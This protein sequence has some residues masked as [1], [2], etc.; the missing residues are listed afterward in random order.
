MR[1]Y[2][3][4]NPE[5]YRIGNDLTPKWE[6]KDPEKM[7]LTMAEIEIYER[8]SEFFFIICKT[9]E[10]AITPKVPFRKTIITTKKTN[11]IR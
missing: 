4:F 7:D 10:K 6:A 2:Q 8:E 1:I 11:F 5:L 9:G 3:Y